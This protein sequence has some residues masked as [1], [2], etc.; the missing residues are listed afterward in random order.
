MKIAIIGGSGSLG[1]GL[2]VRLAG[3]HD[4]L[5][6]SR[7]ETKGKQ[8]AKKLSTLTGCAIDGGAA[9]AVAGIS[10]AALLAMPYDPGSE[11]LAK[12]RKPL[13]G[14]LVVSPMVPMKV[15][16]GRFVYSLTEGSAAQRVAAI[17]GESRLAA[18][19]HTVPAPLLARA[20]AP[21]E[22]DVPVAAEK[23]Q[24]F[25]EAASIIRDIGSLRP[26][27]A[28]DL[29][30]ARGLEEL[31]PLLLNLARLNGLRNLSVRFV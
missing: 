9:P 30:Q 11:L 22:F 24:T 20:D 21:L 13:S 28:G 1:T 17:L 19:L 14:K 26:L 27:Y 4:V 18:A 5:I 16:D 10:D 12:L 23:E 7:D 3:T 8:A 15:E 31:V 25:E 29:R 2:A 6:G